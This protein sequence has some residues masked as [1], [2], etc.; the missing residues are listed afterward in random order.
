[1]GNQRRV[2]L[3]SV[4]KKSKTSKNQ[5]PFKDKKEKVHCFPGLR[6][7]TVSYVVLLFGEHERANI[8]ERRTL[9]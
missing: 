4:D 8:S 9:T 2:Q 3:E 6:T 7:D 5:K 1:M